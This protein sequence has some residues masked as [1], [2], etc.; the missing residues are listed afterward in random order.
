QMTFNKTHYVFKLSLSKSIT[1]IWFIEAYDSVNLS[2]SSIK[3]N[4]T[5]LSPSSSMFDLVPTII[6]AIIGTFSGIFALYIA[7]TTYQKRKK[8][9]L[10]EISLSRQKLDSLSNTYM[11]LVTT[12]VGLPIYT[13]NNVMYQSSDAIKDVLSGLSVGVDSFLESFQSDIIKCLDIAT[14][15]ELAESETKDNIKASII[16]KNKVQI[17]IISSPSFR[18]FLFLKEKPPEYVKSAFTAIAR[19]L[20]EKISLSE[21][22]VFEEN[23]VGLAVEKII[24]QH[25]PIALLSHFNLDYQRVKVIE[26]KLKRGDPISKSFTKSSLNALKRLVFVKS[27][28]DVSINHPQTQIELIDNFFTQDKIQEI[29]PIILSEALDIFKILKVKPKVMYEALWVGSSP[30]VNVI[31]SRENNSQEEESIA[32]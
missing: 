26:E 18:I 12:A 30:E 1:M 4:Y 9:Q 15:S 8:Q 10:S 6:L 13:V 20:E 17:Q 5:F 25:F 21:L 29:P 11:I 28:I 2:K 31:I 7:S 24:K 19:T 32:L 16:E 14:D 3:R 22:G 23:L 27:N